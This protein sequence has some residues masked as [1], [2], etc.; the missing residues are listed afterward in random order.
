MAEDA[1]EPRDDEASSSDDGVPDSP[2]E[3]RGHRADDG[4]VPHEVPGDLPFDAGD[5]EE[6]T[7]DMRRETG[8]GPAGD[9]PD[10]APA[11]DAPDD[12]PA[13]DATDAEH[14]A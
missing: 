13:D 3:R 10:D 1:D 6:T 2:D 5:G 12:A 7:A 4:D 11:G 8:A 14:P 9:A